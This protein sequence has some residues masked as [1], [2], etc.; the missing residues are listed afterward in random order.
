[1][2]HLTASLAFC[3]A[4]LCAVAVH[5]ARIAPWT[6]GGD[7]GFHVSSDAGGRSLLRISQAGCDSYSWSATGELLSASNAVARD[8]TFQNSVPWILIRNVSRG[9]P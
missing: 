7:V 1:M 5:A 3:T 6:P 2:K 9:T 8:M 4:L